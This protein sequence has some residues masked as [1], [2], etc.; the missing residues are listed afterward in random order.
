MKARKTQGAAGMNEEN[1]TIKLLGLKDFP[2]FA[3]EFGGVDRIDKKTLIASDIL[4]GFQYLCIH[5]A[6]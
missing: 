2:A 4:D 1:I 6:E 5:R 3:E